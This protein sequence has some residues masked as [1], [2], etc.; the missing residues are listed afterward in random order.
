MNC[1]E[2][3]LEETNAQKNS[4]SLFYSPK[5]VLDWG[6]FAAPAGDDVPR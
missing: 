3:G 6:V 2:S 4:R 1:N 5:Q